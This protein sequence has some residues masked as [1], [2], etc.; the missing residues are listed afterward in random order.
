MRLRKLASALSAIAAVASIAPAGALAHKHSSPN[1]RCRIDINV[2]PNVITAGDPVVIFGRLVCANPAREA[3]QTVRL[4]HN[5]RGVGGGFT[6]IQS[7]STD[8]SG[9]YDFTRADG[10]VN[11]NRR[12]FVRS[13]G[14]QS[15]KKALKVAAA[16]TLSGPAEGTQIYTG[17]PNAVTFT[18]TVSP[19]DVGA[20]VILQR[21]NALTGNEW[22]AIDRGFVGAGGS[23]T[24]MHTFRVPGD[25]DIRVLVR[26][27]G[28]NIPSASAPLSYE[29]S[30]TQNQAL[31]INSS[32]D[33]IQYGQTVTI[34]GVLAGAVNHPVTLYARTAG[35]RFGPVSQVNTDAQG[36]YS[37]PAQTPLNS[38]F[39]RVLS[40]GLA[41]S[42]E[43]NYVKACKSPTVKSAV[44]Y[45]GVK[46][47]LTATASPTTVQAGAPVTFSGAV[48]PDHTGDVIYLERLNA[49]GS[50][51]HV[52][53]VATIEAGSVYSIEHRF[54]D[55][56]IKTVRIHVPGGPQNGSAVSQPF[57]ITVTPVPAASLLPE[58]PS[59]SSLPAEGQVQG[60]QGQ[61][62]GGEGSAIEQEDETK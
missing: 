52:I 35:Q 40:T 45:E 43:V 44:L 6:Y 3:H 46:S 24:I 9:F 15:A 42:K 55:P 22:H 34:G 60:G 20:R 47:V 38:T 48:A 18:G 28:R 1:G 10:V 31:T 8:G 56:G 62:T 29:I 25:A 33:P 61:E 59:N 2:V 58:A 32:A 7:T 11:T 49:S 16:V 5:L 30:Q 4:F 57:D 54:Y 37:F 26:S 23:F 51:Y 12:F 17:R 13:Q 41:C 53:Q 50:G 39:Y 14:A 27:Q 19:A 36:N 21:Q